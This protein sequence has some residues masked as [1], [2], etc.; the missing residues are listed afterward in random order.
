LEQL[1][2]SNYAEQN[3][4]SPIKLALGQMLSAEEKW[5]NSQFVKASASMVGKS[6]ANPN[7]IASR[8]NKL[9]FSDSEFD[10][11]NLNDSNFAKKTT[12]SVLRSGLAKL[13]IAGWKNSQSMKASGMLMSKMKKLDLA[14][15][16]EV[17]DRRPSPLPELEDEINQKKTIAPTVTKEGLTY[18]EKSLKD[19]NLA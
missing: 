11:E 18:L 9:H 19:Q 10:F 14:I 2:E 6:K 8:T 16:P 4:G 15:V 17:T 1:N 7:V 12:G 5:K 13:A 3:T